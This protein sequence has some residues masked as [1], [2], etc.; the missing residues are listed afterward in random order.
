MSES[1]TRAHCTLT[2][3]LEQLARLRDFINLTAPQFGCTEEDTFAFELAC[4][5]A[6]ANIFAHA[7]ENKTGQVQV[8]FWRH[9]DTVSVCLM[10]H[11]RSFDPSEVPEPD[12]AAPLEKRPVGGL[13]LFFMRQLMSDVNFEFDAVNGNKLTMHRVLM[14]ESRGNHDGP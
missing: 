3:S 10:Y 6:A 8:E 7:F 13:G 1:E 9:D 14:M 11:G 12:L 4:D 2:G 5:E